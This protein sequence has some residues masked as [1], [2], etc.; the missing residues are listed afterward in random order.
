MWSPR[1]PNATQTA[2]IALLDWISCTVGRSIVGSLDP[3]RGRVEVKW[4]LDPDPD[5]HR[6]QIQG[7]VWRAPLSWLPINSWLEKVWSTLTKCTLFN[8]LLLS[9]Q[10]KGCTWSVSH[11]LP[12][13]LGPTLHNIWIYWEAIQ[14]HHTYIYCWEA[15]LKY[16]IY[17]YITFFGT[18]KYIQCPIHQTHT[19]KTLLAQ[20]KTSETTL[21]Q[22]PGDG[23]STEWNGGWGGQ[24]G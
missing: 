24:P 2:H 20:R 11:L 7:P 10:D 14:I 16:C 12:L 22:K 9:N 21:Q 18:Y 6:I 5:P 23:R 13:P 17:M 1:V 19:V 4:S 8:W 3:D 15:I